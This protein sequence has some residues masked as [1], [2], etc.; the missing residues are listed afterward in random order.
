MYKHVCVYIYIYMHKIL[1]AQVPDLDDDMQVGGRVHNYRVLGQLKIADPPMQRHRIP[2]FR[3]Y[4]GYCP[5][6]LTVG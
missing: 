4:L 3:L 1:R 2:G 6:S 5:L